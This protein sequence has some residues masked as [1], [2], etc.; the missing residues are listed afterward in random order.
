[1]K[2]KQAKR[3]G[4]FLLELMIVIL[5]FC[6]TSAVCVRLFVKSHIISQDTRNLNMAVNQVSKMA[7]VFRSGAD[8]QGFIEHE[9]L[10]YDK[11]TKSCLYRL[12]YNKNWETDKKEKA[13]FCLSVE[14]FQ[15]D[16][17][18]YGYFSMRNMSTNQDIYAVS[19]Q[20]F[21]G[22]VIP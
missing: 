4:I 21:K 1:M 12:Y 11:E 14:I 7:E 22:E 6:M 17:K 10:F 18:E 20:K 2:R 19:L 3:S 8:M 15:D 16:S 9:F 13:R 5:F